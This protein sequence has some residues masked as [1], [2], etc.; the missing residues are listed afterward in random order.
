MAAPDGLERVFV[1]LLNKGPEARKR[2]ALE[3]GRAAGVTRKQANSCLYHHEELFVRR[4]AD[5]GPPTWWLAANDPAAAGQP[6]AAAQAAPPA[7]QQRPAATF[8][9]L[10]LP[11]L[12]QEEVEAED[13]EV[14]GVV[15]GRPDAAARLAALAEWCDDQLI[16]PAGDIISKGQK[17]KRMFVLVSA[18]EDAGA[19]TLEAFLA[20][21][22]AVSHC[23][24]AAVL[25]G[26][27]PL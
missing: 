6:P 18:P 4:E 26:A 21:H 8:N 10:A 5:D 27:A 20:V 19:C 9:L 12:T 2:T 22:W 25:V 15:C 14:S 13:P 17:P 7:H 1:D 23:I 3:L 16:E 24:P 11:S